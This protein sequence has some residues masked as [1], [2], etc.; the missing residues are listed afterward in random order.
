MKQLKTKT[1]HFQ[2]QHEHLSKYF[3]GIVIV[4]SLE[5]LHMAFRKVIKPHLERSLK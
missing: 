4:R 3:H 1:L 5:T 2:R